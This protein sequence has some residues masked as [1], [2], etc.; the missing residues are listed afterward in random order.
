MMRRVTLTSL[1]LLS[2]PLVATSAPDSHWSAGVS[3]G[4]SD[5][6]IA[7]IDDQATGWKAFGGYQFT[8]NFAFELSYYDTGAFSENIGGD[9]FRLEADAVGAALLGIIPM[10]ESWAIY[11]RAGAIDWD[12]KERVTGPGGSITASDD[13]T[14][15]AWGVGAKIMGESGAALRLEYEAAEIDDW[16]FAFISL[17]VSFDF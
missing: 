1:L 4:Q 14:D 10:S 5:I 2:F 6:D 17:S 3:I 13:G 9:S 16:D 7:G 8:R 11:A 12:A 15:F